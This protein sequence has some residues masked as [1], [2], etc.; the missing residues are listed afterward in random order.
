MAPKTLEN[1]KAA[2]LG[3]LNDCPFLQA[4]MTDIGCALRSGDWL[5]AARIKSY[6]WILLAF[7]MATIAGWIALSDGLIDLKEGDLKLIDGRELQQVAAAA[8]HQNKSKKFR[9]KK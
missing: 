4:E 3:C 1:V 9:K 8:Q 6:S 2:P 5:T 7:T